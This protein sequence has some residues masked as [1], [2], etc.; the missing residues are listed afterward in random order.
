MTRENILLSQYYLI[1]W[2]TSIDNSNME[3][4]SIFII[5]IVLSATKLQLSRYSNKMLCTCNE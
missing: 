1:W 4:V 3:Y 2:I 5:H